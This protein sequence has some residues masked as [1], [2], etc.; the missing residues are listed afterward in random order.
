MYVSSGPLEARRT[1]AQT[2]PHAP[3]QSSSSSYRNSNR[4]TRFTPSTI[5]RIGALGGRADSQK[6]ATVSGKD[7]PI[8]ETNGRKFDYS[9]G[10]NGLSQ[11]RPEGWRDWVELGIKLFDLP[12]TT[13]I[14]DLYDRFSREGTIA[15]IE[16]YEDTKGLPDGKACVRFR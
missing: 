12:V 10:F 8:F 7:R 11:S 14:H 13:T 9:R 15:Y 3:R 2:T 16:I 1:G 4:S 5:S 6:T